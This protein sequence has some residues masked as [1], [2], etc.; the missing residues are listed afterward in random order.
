MRVN[1]RQRARIHRVGHCTFCVGVQQTVRVLL[2]SATALVASAWPQTGSTVPTVEAIIARMA[3]ARIENQ[4]RF[5]PYVV[6]R[7]Y[8]LFGQERQKSKSEVTADV[9][10]VP[11]DRKQ[12]AIQQSQGSGLGEILVRRMLAGEADIAKNSTST[13]FSPQNYDFRFVREE[14]VE[15]QLCY[16]LELLPKRK[17]RNLVRGNVW[18][19]VRTY[20]LRRTE[21]QPAKS[22]SWWLRDVRMSFSYGEVSGMWLQTSSEATATVRILGQHTMVMRDMKYTLGELVVAGSIPAFHVDLPVVP[23]TLLD[24]NTSK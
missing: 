5:R 15:G 10:F 16:M 1:P 17:D 6:T 2:L 20:L 7:G 8:T 19:D 4:S 24:R 14:D 22:P 21:G 11:P 12:Y 9:T 13:D 3:Q 23:A 18:V